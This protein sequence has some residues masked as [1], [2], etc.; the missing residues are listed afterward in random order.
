M[1]PNLIQIFGTKT[2]ALEILYL[3]EDIKPSVRQGFYSSELF[4][5]QKFCKENNLF[6]EISP[7]KIVIL[8]AENGEYSNKGIKA[9]ISDPRDGML[10]VYISKEKEKA[11]QAKRLEIHNSYKILGEVL[12]Y[13][14]C[15]VNFFM[16]NQSKQSKLDNDYVLPALKNSKGNNF[17]FYNNVIK[18]DHDIILLSHFPCSFNCEESIKIGKQNV[19]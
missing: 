19:D 12:G 9:D 13:P 10:F 2:K 16:R 14:K 15:C 1:I 4:A 17:P 6:L 8:D 5:V 3:L 7:Y 18:R 11:E